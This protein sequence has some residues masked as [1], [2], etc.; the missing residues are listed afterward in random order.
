MREREKRGEE[1][2]GVGEI[3]TYVI[4]PIVPAACGCPYL[5]LVLILHAESLFDAVAS[6]QEGLPL[7]SFCQD[8]HKQSWQVD[9][10]EQHCVGN[11][12]QTEKKK[13]H[14]M[15]FKFFSTVVNSTYSNMYEEMSKTCCEWSCQLVFDS[16]IYLFF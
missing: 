1:K 13:T 16:Y 14:D 3:D 6:L 5:L 11:Q 12:L 2:G 15:L 9:A 4:F 10:G 8:A 7:G